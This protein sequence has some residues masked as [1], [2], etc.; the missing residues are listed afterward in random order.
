LWL[1]P[2]RRGDDTGGCANRT[3]YQRTDDRA[4]ATTGCRTDRGAGAG[5]NQRA[6]RGTLARVIGIGAGGHRQDKTNRGG[7][8]DAST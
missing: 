8:F 1:R 7:I 4:M 2:R 3:A 6:T 5:T